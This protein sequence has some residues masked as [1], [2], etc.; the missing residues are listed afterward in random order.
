MALESMH[1][2]RTRE[3]VGEVYLPSQKNGIGL[4]IVPSSAGVVDVRER[5]YARFFA[6]NGLH[7]IIADP[8]ALMGLDQCLTDQTAMPMETLLSSAFEARRRLFEESNL[9]LCGIMG[10]SKGGAVALLSALTLPWLAAQPYFD[11]HTAL[12]PPVHLQ[13]RNP[14]ATGGPI[15]ILL[16]EDDD[17]TPAAPALAYAARIKN[18]NPDLDLTVRVLPNHAHAW[19]SRGEIHWLPFAERYDHCLFMLENDGSVTDEANGRNM[20]LATLRNGLRSLARRGAHYGGGDDNSFAATC[21]QI[22]SFIMSCAR[23]KSVE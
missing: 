12:V 17:F 6:Q 14:R 22:L 11:F 15:L 1:T 13:L 19:E 7:C 3:F 9:R 23:K 16:G 20:T 4:V 8:F 10:V 21:D 2:I 5:A 18:K